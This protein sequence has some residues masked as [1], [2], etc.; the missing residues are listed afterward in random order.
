MKPSIAIIG[1]GHI[2]HFHVPALRAAGFNIVSCCGSPNS[3][4]AKEFA[5][6]H[7]IKKVYLDVDSLLIDSSGFRMY[8]NCIK[9]LSSTFEI[10]VKCLKTGLPIL[11]EKP[12]SI[13]PIE[14]LSV[15]EDAKNICVGYNRRFYSTVEFAKK[16][17]QN[18]NPCFVKLELPD[19]LDFSVQKNKQSFLV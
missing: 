3:R 17:I 13:N 4:R 2:S 16:F 19:N 11:V 8:S 15:S 18:N 12:V 1:T 6:K 14:L 5:S 7:D 9:C 10:L